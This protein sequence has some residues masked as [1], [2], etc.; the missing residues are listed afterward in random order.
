MSIVLRILAAYALL[1]CTTIYM[2][3]KGKQTHYLWLKALTSFLF[4]RVALAAPAALGSVAGI[5]MAMGLMFCMAG[6][7]LLAVAHE[8]D[9]VLINKYFK[10]GVISFLIAHLCFCGGIFG[11]LGAAPRLVILAAAA[12][13]ATVGITV[14]NGR[15]D[16]YDYQGNYEICAVY[17]F[18]VGALL[19][20]GIHVLLLFLGQGVGLRYFLLPAGCILFL[21][22][23]L[24]L[25]MKLFMKRKYPAFPALV[26]VLYYTATMC[27]ALFLHVG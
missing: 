26:L 25:S 24:V 6:D 1:A 21:L 20:C 4:V 10:P 15:S 23:D 13:A 27:L 14:M 22:S 8:I 16:Q 5:L 17:S 19:G 18:F 3:Y 2:M 12:G 11:M 7:V 9:N